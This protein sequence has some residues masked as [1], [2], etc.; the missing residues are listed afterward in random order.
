MI[1]WTRRGEGMRGALAAGALVGLA[2]AVKTPLGLAVL[3][4]LPTARSWREAG[5]VAA[6]AV[7]VPL[8]MLAPFLVADASGTVD[9][10]R[11][12]GLPGQGGLSLIV[13]PHVVDAWVGHT[14]LYEEKNLL[15]PV[16][17]L[18]NAAVIAG[19]LLVTVRRRAPA[20]PAAIFVWLAVFAFGSGFTF[21]FVLWLV[22]FLLL[23]GH[24]RAAVLAQV[25]M[26]PPA[27]LLV[28]APFD[29][30]V[31]AAYAVWMIVAWLA[32]VAALAVAYRG[33]A[34]TA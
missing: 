23:A 20:V 16:T 21:S 2:A 27:L 5:T 19:I 6:A 3:A 13:Q 25:A 11:Y 15:E 29:A 22:P 9:A 26:V 24:L 18:I 32:T 17:G 33:L 30:P 28:T 4:L 14:P 1:L 7:A 31:P 10:F 8:A 34:R 12:S